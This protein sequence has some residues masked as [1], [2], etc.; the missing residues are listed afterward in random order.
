M[1]MRTANSETPAESVQ[2]NRVAAQITPFEAE[3]M[4]RLGATVRQHRMA[5]GLSRHHVAEWLGQSAD[6]LA[7]MEAG[8]RRFTVADVLRLALEFECSVD[9]LI[10][11]GAPR[12]R[13]VR[14]SKVE[15]G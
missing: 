15:F 12:P 13:I 14:Q 5:R 2:A 10:T 3:V 4:K 1:P 8:K 7:K 9:E 11:G 6:S